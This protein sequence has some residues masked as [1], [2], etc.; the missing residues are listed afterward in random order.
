MQNGE[1]MIH[2]RKLGRFPQ[3]PNAKA[4]QCPTDSVAVFFFLTVSVASPYDLQGC[5]GRASGARPVGCLLCASGGAPFLGGGS[6]SLSLSLSIR[7][8]VAH[9]GGVDLFLDLPEYGLHDRFASGVDLPT[10]L[11]V[12]LGGHVLAS[13]WA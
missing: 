13:R 10:S 8:R 7:M 1:V 12:Q 6:L 4:V 9:H 2:S 3:S 5:L 11:T